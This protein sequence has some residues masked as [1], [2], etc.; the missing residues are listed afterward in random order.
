METS[1]RSLDNL[2]FD[3]SCL[4]NLPLDPVQE[5]HVRRVT[6]A[7]FSLVAPTPVKNPT[8]V[9]IEKLPKSQILINYYLKLQCR[10]LQ[11]RSVKTTIARSRRDK[12]A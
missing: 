7:C 9:I 1:L 12:E 10:C 4:K 8:Q 6:G 3:N 11:P 5:N 2:Q